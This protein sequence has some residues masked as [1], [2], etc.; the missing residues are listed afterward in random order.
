MRWFLRSVTRIFTLLIITLASVSLFLL[1]FFPSYLGAL[2]EWLKDIVITL[3]WKNYLFAALVSLIES[4][5]FINM[6]FPWII[7]IVMISGFVA[8]TDYRGIAAVIIVFISIGDSIAYLLWSRKG[9][10][11]LAEY[12]SIVWLA[13]ERLEKITSIIKK[14]DNLALFASKWSN[15]TRS[16]IPFFSWLSHTKRWSFTL[17]NALGAIIYGWVVVWLAKFF[18]WNY[19]LVLPYIRI[20]AI[21]IIVWTILWYLIH[22]YVK[23][24][25]NRQ[26]HS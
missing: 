8:Q 21:V 5:P 26:I 25:K 9:E 19:A 4:L 13:P 14:Y 1:L 16:I 2:I 3:G 22:Y 20:I 6:A 23:K 17:W 12:G 11:L 15:Y 24:S 7:I 10:K 18:L